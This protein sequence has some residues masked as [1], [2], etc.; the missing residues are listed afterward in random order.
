MRL[1]EIG[2]DDLAIESFLNTISQMDTNNFIN[3]I[4]VG[5]RESRIF[6]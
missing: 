5:E 1:P 6:S 2:W 3:K 4:G